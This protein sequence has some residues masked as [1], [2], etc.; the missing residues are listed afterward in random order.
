MALSQ[1]EA[2]LISAY[3]LPHY[4]GN[5]KRGITLITALRDLRQNGQVRAEVVDPAT[6]EVTLLSPSAV[7]RGMRK[8]TIAECVEDEAT[9]AML[10]GYGVDAVQGFYLERPHPEPR[11][12]GSPAPADVPG[13]VRHT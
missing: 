1:T 3:I 4:R 8:Q 7:A 11:F 10:K 6:G 13:A 9:L 5:G 12:C 2:E